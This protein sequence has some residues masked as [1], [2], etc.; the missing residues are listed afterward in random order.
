[1]HGAMP[2]HAPSCTGP[3]RIRIRKLIHRFA[4]AFGVLSGDDL[5]RDERSCID[6]SARYL[7]TQRFM[8][9]QETRNL[10]GASLV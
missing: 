6:S 1:M 8:V 7:S 3:S 5:G 9:D 10:A 2:S 4:T